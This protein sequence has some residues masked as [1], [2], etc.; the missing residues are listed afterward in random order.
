MN[1]KKLPARDI[2]HLAR[3]I[4]PGNW[5]IEAERP[6]STL[7][8]SCVAVCLVAPLARI[9]GLNHFLLPNIRR[10]SSAPTDSLLSGDNAM[11]ALL[12]AI[13]AERCQ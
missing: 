10:S 6:L 3:T 9:G 8:G 2:E 7:L 12:D 4:H 1:Y 13:I 5:A 11:A